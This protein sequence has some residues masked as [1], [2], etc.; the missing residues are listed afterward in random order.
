M[1]T[2]CKVTSAALIAALLTG[3]GSAN[4]GS[5]VGFSKATGSED[6]SGQIGQGAEI[7][8][9]GNVISCGCSS[10]DD[11]ASAN[12][13]QPTLEEFIA[14]I[15]DDP[16]EKTLFDGAFRCYISHSGGHGVELCQT[17]DKAQ[18]SQMAAAWKDTRAGE[19]VEVKGDDLCVRPAFILAMP[20]LFDGATV[21]KC[22]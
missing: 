8:A 13:P 17:G 14:A 2:I 1:N 4:F 6:A 3:C 18:L 10:G 12:I 16:N 21:G 11:D 7:D 5:K 15:E 19:P 9:N 20:A 22:N